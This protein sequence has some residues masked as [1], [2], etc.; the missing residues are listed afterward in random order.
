MV[1]NLW[2]NDMNISIQIGQIRKIQTQREYKGKSLIAFPND[3]CVV[4]IETT[5]LYAG[6][7]DIIEIATIKCR[8]GR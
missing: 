4:D 7:D 5:G 6:S 2:E 1:Q 3:Y 8:N